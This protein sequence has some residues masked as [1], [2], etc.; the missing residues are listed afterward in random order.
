VAARRAFFDDLAGRIRIPGIT[1]ERNP[2]FDDEHA[3]NGGISLRY[4]SHF[5]ALPGLRPSVLLEVGFERTAPNEP[6]TFSSWVYDSA[7]AAGLDIA[8][9]RGMS[10]KCFAPEYTFVDKLQTI[11]RRF[12]QFRDRRD[13]VQDVPRQFLRHYYDLFKLLGE[14]RVVRFMKTDAYEEYREQKLG[15]ADAMAF[16]ARSAFTLPDPETYALFKDEYAA[17]RTLVFGEPPSFDEVMARIR[18]Y[19]SSF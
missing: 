14:D 6:R 13:P 5:A 18:H 17:L 8:D 9:N 2:A 15:A 11:C 7:R 16:A 10:V 12:R 3:R 1:T 4:D 19:E